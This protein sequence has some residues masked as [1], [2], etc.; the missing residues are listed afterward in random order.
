MV[1]SKST[2]NTIL[3]PMNTD[4]LIELGFYTLP[5]IVTGFVAIYT[6][7]AFLKNDENKRHFLLKN[8]NQ[9]QA[10]PLKIQA[11]E[12]LTL[13][14][15]RINPSKLL[16]RVA[17]LTDDKI[18]YQ[19]LLI[20]HI[21]QEYE[22]NLTQQMYVSEEC[23]NMIVTAKNTTI[24]NIRKAGINN[25]VANADKLRETILTSLF[26]GESATNLALSYLKTEVKE[27]L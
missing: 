1:W 12:R 19:N 13:L 17:P 6:F 4:R 24:Q 5:A 7:N 2:S 9:K 14:L 20:Q 10:L 25:E 15:E 18:N 27:F 22:H 23:W 8:E 26:E 11:Y 16:L 3:K 21:E